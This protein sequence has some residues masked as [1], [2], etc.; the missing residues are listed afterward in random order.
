MCEFGIIKKEVEM[1]MFEEVA[2]IKLIEGDFKISIIII[3]KEICG[4]CIYEVRMGFY[5]KE[6]IR[7]RGDLK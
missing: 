4:Y 6:L 3:F 5:I 7:D 1:S 2:L